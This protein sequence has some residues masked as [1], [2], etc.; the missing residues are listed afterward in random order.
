MNATDSMVDRQPHF[1]KVGQQLL[2]V[3]YDQEIEQ[4]VT[5]HKM[6]VQ[7]GALPT[8]VL[9]QVRPK[10]EAKN[11]NK[12]E[13]SVP[14][15]A[16]S[17]STPQFLTRT[18]KQH[19]PDSFS[20]L[21]KHSSLVT[22]TKVLQARLT[23][24]GTPVFGD[25]LRT[26]KQVDELHEELEVVHSPAFTQLPGYEEET[27]WSFPVDTLRSIVALG[28]SQS[29]VSGFDISIEPLDTLHA[30]KTTKGVT[31][32]SQEFYELTKF[33]YPSLLTLTS[34]SLTSA[35]AVPQGRSYFQV[36]AVIRDAFEL[37]VPAKFNVTFTST[38]QTPPSLFQPLSQTL[39]YDGIM[40]RF[41]APNVINDG[42]TLTATTNSAD[43]FWG[44]VV[45]EA[46]AFPASPT[47]LT[48]YTALVGTYAAVSFKSEFW[49]YG[50]WKNTTISVPIL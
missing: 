7:H 9:G 2:D 3:V 33:T 36:N 23:G 18:T 50:L 16:F 35:F 10:V 48:A 49:K 8:I 26:T 34:A 11:T 25:L 38:A 44:S 19:A 29:P 5:V 30:L 40:W 47:S 21:M 45:V 17:G 24:I 20:T 37:L 15:V 1:A 12:S 14:C 22:T 42:F 13:L 31:T 32:A 28:T 27:E 46:R 41:Y 39:H 4:N 6:E 43:T